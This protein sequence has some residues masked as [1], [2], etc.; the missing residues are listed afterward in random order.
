[1]GMVG[2]AK[3]VAFVEDTAVSVDRL[4]EFYERFR[5]IVARQGASAACYGHADVGCLH[6]RPILNMKTA[7]GVERLQAIARDVSDLVAEF[8][9]AMSGEHGDGL[10]RSRWNAKLFGPE[11]YEAF[12]TI[13]RAFDPENRLNP[14][15]VVAEPDLAADLRISPDYHTR[16][17]SETV[18]DFS[19][20]GGFARATELCS[21]VGACRKTHT[22]TMCPSYMITRDEE[23]T[24]RGRANALRLVLSGALPAE[25]LSNETLHD[26]LD[27]CLQCKACKTEC[28]SN[29]DM[30]K[31]KA[32]V[33]YQSSLSR[34][35]PLGHH[36]LGNIH[37]LNP[38]GSA[39]AP[40]ANW[41]LRQA[42]LKWLLEKV[43][44]ID[45]RRTLP[46]FAHDHLRRWFRR[47]AADPRAGRRG[48]VILLDDCFTTYNTPEVGRAAVRL[49]EAAGYRVRLAGLSCCGRPAISKGLLP[50]AR[51]LARE[52]VARLVEDARRG[53]PI[54]GCEPSCLLT[55]VDEYRDFRLGPDADLV[56]SVS[57]LVDAFV[58]DPER[59]PDL[60]M[61][62]L[63]A[64]VLLHG[65]CQQK[66]LTGTAGTL[67]A[68]R[69]IPGLEVRELDSGCCGMAGSFGYE[70]GH[71]DLSTALA[72]RVLLPA[73]TAEPEGLLVAPGFSCR[74]QVH[75]LTG[76][77]A[78]H[79]VELL[80]R[81]LTQGNG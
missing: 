75:G 3:P 69:R 27:L 4:P 36:L 70:L 42:P 25:N 1:M 13:K 20:Q 17:P 54:L 10:A 26:A 66:A 44:G 78:L 71:Y 41:S 67:A 39:T 76:Q 21:G 24:T 46:T 61:A 65:H 32:E 62:S 68:L 19:K 64:R 28:P 15:K 30:A 38:L 11:V 59:V 48:E 50:K 72:N 2:D 18:F 74:S 57:R 22:G 8:G 9:G 35:L 16:E 51:D 55:L 7:E 40:L 81:Q 47:H 34:P 49:L 79:P 14:G 60:P 43:A 12:Q 23:H 56:A 73:M 5:E 77:T 45:R 29:V 37:R 6:I 52:N 33:L 63:P 80:A 31:L 53:T 58:A